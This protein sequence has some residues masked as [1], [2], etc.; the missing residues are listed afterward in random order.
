VERAMKVQEVILK[1]A[2]SGIRRGRRAAGR[3]DAR[4]DVL[5][6]AVSRVQRAPLSPDRAAGARGNALVQLSGIGLG[7][8]LVVVAAASL[9]RRERRR[10][11]EAR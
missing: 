3:A 11:A 10:A 1:A 6:R 4:A 5:S 7:I 8:L 9:V 2:S